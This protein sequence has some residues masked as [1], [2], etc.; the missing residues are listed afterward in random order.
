MH[1]I[2]CTRRNVLVLTGD[3]V[4][5][6]YRGH[7]EQLFKGNIGRQ[8]CFYALGRN[9]RHG[10][11][12]EVHLGLESRSGVEDRAVPP[13]RHSTPH[14]LQMGP[15]LPARGPR[16]SRRPRAP[17]HHPQQIAP[18][19]VARILE[20]R[21][22]HPLWGAEK[23]RAVLEREQPLQHPPAASTI[24]EIL[25]HEGL[26]RPPKKR[27]R[28][29]PY[30]EPLAHAK[31]P[32]DVV[33]IDFKGWFLCRDGS[34]IDPLTLVDN[35]SRYALCCQAV[36]ACNFVQ[37]RRVLESVF[38]Q[39]GLPRAIRSDNGA[40]FA[41]RAIKG[42]SRLSVWWLRLGIEVERIPPARPSANGRQERFHRTLKQHTA[43][44]PAANRRA[45]QRAFESFCCEYNEQR[46][47][48]AFP[49]KCR[50]VSIAPRIV[51]IRRSCLRS[52]I[53][54]AFCGARWAS[55]ARS[56]GAGRGSS[57]A[58][59]ST[60]NRWGSR[61]SPTGSIGSGSAR[62]SWARSTSA[63]ASSRRC[64]G[65]GTT[66]PPGRLRRFPTAVKHRAALN[67]GQ[68]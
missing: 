23:I 34:R 55:A 11:T 53:R 20:I 68:F 24:G 1:K 26:T 17:H 51:L 6:T 36:D 25:H 13:L 48:Q 9:T 8:Q 38:L 31:E 22:Q 46:P 44:P 3:M 33:S 58:R 30:S 56:T 45:Q 15:A 16:R 66:A 49:S 42:L 41:S 39:Y 4:N 27:R 57:S 60:G 18:Q 12:Y 54:R 7:G 52:S 63:A 47:H 37:V 19:V 64:P 59:C 14:R 29:P 21:G 35:A 28:T 67:P 43:D 2:S 50:P 40:P 5:K 65:A 62:C 10:S 61:R 32:N